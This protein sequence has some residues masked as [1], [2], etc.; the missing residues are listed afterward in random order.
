VDVAAEAAPAGPP[1]LSIIAIV[2]AVL[3]ALITARGPVWLERAKARY[4]KD[5]GAAESKSNTS[6]P[7]VIE[8]TDRAIDLVGEAMSDYRKERD[9]F[10]EELRLARLR[11]DYLEG[12]L[13]L[14]GWK[15]DSS[16]G[17]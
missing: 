9:E 8:R 3:V 2:S 7:P 10:R 17:R 11:I 13:Y 14:R 4:G 6:T 5:K 16:C 12:Q 15:G 1:W